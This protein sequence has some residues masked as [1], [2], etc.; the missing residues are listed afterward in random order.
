MPEWFA[1]VVCVVGFVA[2]WI[3]FVLFGNKMKWGIVEAERQLKR[4]GTYAE[5]HKKNR[6]L[7]KLPNIGGYGYIAS[8][9]TLLVV[10]ILS[11]A[12]PWLANVARLALV[13][14]IVLAIL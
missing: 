1:T 9:F 2:L 6:I 11:N 13:T 10:G 5:W 12:V 7:A 8:V 4:N 3:P 14:M